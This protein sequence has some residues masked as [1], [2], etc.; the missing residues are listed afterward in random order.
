MY[1]FVVEN[2]WILGYSKLLHTMLC[3]MV[4]ESKVNLKEVFISLAS[5]F[6][7]TSALPSLKM[8]DMDS[9]LMAWSIYIQ[10]DLQPTW[11]T[12]SSGMEIHLKALH[13]T[14]INPF[15]LWFTLI[16]LVHWLRT[17][18]T[19]TDPPKPKKKKKDPDFIRNFQLIHSNCI[20][21][22][23]YSKP[24]F[25]TPQLPYGHILLFMHRFNI[26]T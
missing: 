9:S 7:P 18:L 3:E 22:E 6:L 2:S 20:N 4:T 12:D 24:S 5:C 10:N 16:M 11:N 19:D 17:V 1:R 13:Y 15:P 25:P 23:P 14:L 21:H 8:S 26:M